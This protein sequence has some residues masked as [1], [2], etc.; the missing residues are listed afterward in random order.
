[1]PIEH[2]YPAGDHDIS[3]LAV[4]ADEDGSPVIWHRRPLKSLTG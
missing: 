4:R 1:V 3:V 2:T